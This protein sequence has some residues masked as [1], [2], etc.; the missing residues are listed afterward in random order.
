MGTGYNVAIDALENFL[1]ERENN[2]YRAMQDSQYA[3]EDAAHNRLIKAAIYS[4]S[5][6]DAGM[7]GSFR[8]LMSL[9]ERIAVRTV[10]EDKIRNRMQATLTR[11]RARGYCNEKN[12][13][14]FCEKLVD[15]APDRLFMCINAAVMSNC[16]PDD[17]SEV[18]ANDADELWTYVIEYVLSQ[19]EPEAFGNIEN[20]TLARQCMY[21]LEDI[22]AT[23]F[24]RMPALA[25]RDRIAAS[26]EIKE[27]KNAARDAVKKANRQLKKVEKLSAEVDLK[28]QL[29]DSASE[30]LAKENELLRAKIKKLERRNIAL[31]N[32]LEEEDEETP[33]ENENVASE[34]PTTLTEA[35]PAQDPYEAYKDV[36]LPEDKTMVF[37]GGDYNMIKKM[38]AVHPEWR[39]VSGDFRNNEDIAQVSGSKIRCVVFFS[40]HVSHKVSLRVL[41]NID[42]DVPVIFLD[43]VNMDLVD[44]KIKKAYYEQ[45][46]AAAEK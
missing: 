12:Y 38:R 17:M 14:E 28:K 7:E 15:L 5:A 31:E 4:V 18:L 1:R 22:Y 36:V 11:M 29:V 42:D 19:T 10:D 45:V 25:L 35:V 8:D 34:A 32:L 41:D 44:K 23:A 26:E 30:K 24:L 40:K 9:S 3:K 2:G 20:R 21:H 16:E 27:K 46:L 33:A 37:L 43:A 6:R 39:Y 13:T